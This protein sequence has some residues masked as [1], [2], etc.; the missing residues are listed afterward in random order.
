[1]TNQRKA[2]PAPGALLTPIRYKAGRAMPGYSSSLVF[3][4]D[5]AYVRASRTTRNRAE[6]FQSQVLGPHPYTPL[7]RNRVPRKLRKM[8]VRGQHSAHTG[9]SPFSLPHTQESVETP[10]IQSLH[11]G[12]W[13]QAALPSCGLSPYYSMRAT[14]Q[15]TELCQRGSHLEQHRKDESSTVP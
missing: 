14:G 9:R 15:T 2:S 4:R 13:Q 11:G 7:K 5:P 6:C 1:M 10:S 12:R 8:G 3:T